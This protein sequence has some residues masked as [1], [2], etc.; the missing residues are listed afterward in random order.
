M[1]QSSNNIFTLDSIGRLRSLQDFELLFCDKFSS[2][3]PPLQTTFSLPTPPRIGFV[4][5]NSELGWKLP[6]ELHEILPNLKV[7]R[8]TSIINCLAPLEDS[9][10]SNSCEFMGCD[11][12]ELQVEEGGT[13]FAQGFEC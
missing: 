9:L 11:V 1:E 5:Q 13:T 8:L 7:S 2:L 4:E 6:I 12:K 10:N 3:F